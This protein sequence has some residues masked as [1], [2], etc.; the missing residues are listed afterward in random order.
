MHEVIQSEV[1]GLF[2]PYTVNKAAFVSVPTSVVR[3][4]GDGGWRNRV[5]A[6][7]GKCMWYFG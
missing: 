3:W 2:V 4:E 6:L 7:I 5:A 1:Y